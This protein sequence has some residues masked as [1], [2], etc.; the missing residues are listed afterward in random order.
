MSINS[1][2]ANPH[3]YD[4]PISQ[5]Q[6]TGNETT[7]DR[8]ILRWANLQPGDLLTRDSLRIARQNILDTSLFKQ[9][10]IKTTHGDDQVVVYIDLEEKYYTLLLP[11]LGRNS[12]GDVKSGLKLRMHNIAGANQTLN[13]LTEQTDHSDGNESQRYHIDYNLPQFSKPYYYQWHI[14]Q[15]TINTY[16][17]NFDNIENSQ[18]IS[19]SVARDMHTPLF[20][21]PVTLN[22]WLNFEEVSLDQP[23]PEE[24]NEIEAGRFNRLGF[25]FKY[26]NIHQ[27][28]YRRYGRYYSLS[29]QQGLTQLE[30]DFTSRIVE[31]ESHILRPLNTRDNLNYRMFIGISDD[32]P[33]NSNYY[34]L[35][36]ADNVRGLERDIYSGNA[37]VFGNFEYVTGYAE[38][39]SFR[40]SLFFDVGNVFDDASSIDIGDLYTA[41]GFG[42]RWKLTSFIKTDLIIDVA[43]DPD[44]GETRGYGGTHLNF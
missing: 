6:I 40:T 12:N 39:P 4:L 8:F 38:Y 26:D 32:S 9:V 18:Y 15:S 21:Q 13:M 27:Q 24:F 22:V 34:H 23:Y 42:M 2:H 7:Q 30:S 19:F 35:G 31:F 33:F 16:Q 43:Y 20:K 25:A 41:V 14:G 44:S 10:N 11:R 36:G 37:I 5:I 1:S 29:Y 17:D 28:R 3:F